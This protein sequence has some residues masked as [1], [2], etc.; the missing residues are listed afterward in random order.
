MEFRRRSKALHLYLE[1]DPLSAEIDDEYG[2]SL[3]LERVRWQGGV[4]ER[5]GSCYA[6][7]LEKTAERARALGLKG[8]TTTL[9]ASRE[10]D[11]DRVARAGE[12][13][14]EKYGVRFF[15]ADLRRLLPDEKLLRGI[16]KQQYCG[17]VFSEFERFRG[18]NKHL[19]FPG[20]M[21]DH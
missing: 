4:Q 21:R 2:L 17:C 3:Y 6:L 18:T 7:R 20:G 19:Y 16:Y 10:Q 12:Q 9:L 11:R 13:A 8:F 14:A 5:C 1:R 15:P